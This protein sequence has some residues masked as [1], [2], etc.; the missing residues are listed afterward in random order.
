VLT[1]LAAGDSLIFRD[2]PDAHYTLLNL[3]I[4]A[5]I[6]RNQPASHIFLSSSRIDL[7]SSRIDLPSSRIDLPSSRIDLP[8]SRIDLPS[9]RIDLI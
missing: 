5:I 6:I 1:S 3:P 7:P 4:L 2:A 9:S 8:S